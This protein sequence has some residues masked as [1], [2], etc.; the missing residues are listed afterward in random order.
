ME[1]K[2]TYTVCWEE[3][4]QPFL[5]SCDAASVSCTIDVFVHWHTHNMWYVEDLQCKHSDWLKS[6]KRVLWKKKIPGPFSAAEHTLVSSSLL[7]QLRVNFHDQHHI[8]TWQAFFVLFISITFL[9]LLF[10]F[11]KQ[12]AEYKRSV[13]AEAKVETFLVASVL[14][15]WNPSSGQEFVSL[16]HQH[17]FWRQF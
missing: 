8:L 13:K 10:E 6:R 1:K 17:S 2:C 11:T 4:A 7:T 12:H 3:S 16:P 15:H 14:L 5:Q 9:L